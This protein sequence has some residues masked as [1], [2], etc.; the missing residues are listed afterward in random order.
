MYRSWSSDPTRSN[1]PSTLSGRGPSPLCASLLA[2]TVLSIHARAA[3]RATTGETS[4]CYCRPEWEARKRACCFAK[5]RSSSNSPEGE[6]SVSVGPAPPAPPT[7]CAVSAATYHGD[8]TRALQLALAWLVARR[9]HK[10]H[11]AGSDEALTHYVPLELASRHTRTCA[12]HPPC[13]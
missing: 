2:H 11:T 12:V 9:A 6:V 5:G 1:A 8:N 4:C 13:P 7:P 10:G 3:C